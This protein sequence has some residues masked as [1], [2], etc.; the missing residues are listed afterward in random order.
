MNLERFADLIKESADYI[1][2][3]YYDVRTHSVNWPEIVLSD[4][5]PALVATEYYDNRFHIV[6]ISADDITKE[7][8]LLTKRI[9]TLRADLMTANNP[10]PIEEEDLAT[11]RIHY[12][13]LKQKEARKKAL[14]KLSEEDRRILGLEDERVEI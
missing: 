10:P 8:S 5:P 4:P 14:A 11:V 3:N 1:R 6:P 7:I 2:D 13:C 9:E 12:R